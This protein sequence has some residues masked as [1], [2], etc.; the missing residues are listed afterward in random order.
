VSIRIRE[1]ERADLPTL[2]RLYNE[3]S[4]DDPREDEAEMERYEAAFSAIAAISG[5][6]VLVAEEDGRLLGSVTV[7]VEPN[8]TYQGTPFAIIENV[9][10]TEIA[11]G[12][13]VG[14][15]IM[16]AAIEIAQEAG[17]YKVSLTSNKRRA[18]AHR[19]YEGLG[20]KASHEGFQ[21]RMK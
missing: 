12:K 6:R 14:A 7:I 18:D 8:L 9:V 20:F 16:N 2:I 10:V 13:G 3:L 17:C 21:L 11:R 1:A 4:L 15:L 5:H 19:F